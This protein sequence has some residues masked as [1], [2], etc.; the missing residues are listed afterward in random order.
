MVSCRSDRIQLI[1]KK[2]MMME[3]EMECND[4]MDR[5]RKLID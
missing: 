1:E 4:V 3:V 5:V 2:A